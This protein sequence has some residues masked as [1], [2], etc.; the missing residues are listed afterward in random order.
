MNENMSYKR[1]FWCH[2]TVDK[3]FIYFNKDLF[4][5]AKRMFRICMEPGPTHCTPN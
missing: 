4:T 3:Y 2:S 1:D 5:D